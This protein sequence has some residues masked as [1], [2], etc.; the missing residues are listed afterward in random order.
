MTYQKHLTVMFARNS[1]LIRHYRTHT[2]EKHFACQVCDKKF[3]K[4]TNLVQHQA[5][6]SKVRS[7]KCSISHKSR[8]FKAKQDLNL[9]K[10]FHY[11]PKFACS[12]CDNKTHTKSNLNNHKK[13][14]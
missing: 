12:H 11:E 4:K 9:H 3:A 1:I 8:Y 13:S 10:V 14:S 5:T 6:H 7:F 2:E